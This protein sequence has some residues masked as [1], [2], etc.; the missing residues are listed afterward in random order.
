MEININQWYRRTAVKTAVLIAGMLGG[1]MFLSSV[2]MSFLLIGTVNPAGLITAANESYEESDDFRDAVEGSISEVFEQ[3][4]IKS[5]VETDGAYNP[6]K[7]IDIMGYAETG[8][9]DGYNRSGVAYPMSVLVDWG[10]E[11][12]DESTSSYDTNNVIVCQKPDGSYYYYYLSDFLALFDSG[13]FTIQFED[14]Y[15]TQEGFLEQ[16]EAGNLT[17]ASV[18]GQMQIVDGGGT[19]VYRD[20]WNF[21]RS[22]QEKYEPSGASDL[23][24]LVNRSEELNGKLSLIYNDLALSLGA[25]YRDYQIYQNGW[26]YL[27]EGNTNFTYLYVDEETQEIYTN[28]EEYRNYE[29]TS[30]Y[31]DDMKSWNHVKY[32][33]I[34]P[35]LKECETNMDLSLSEEWSMV[36]SYSENYGDSG[37]FAVAVDTSYPVQD[38]YWEGAAL[39]EKQVPMFN[40]AAFFFFTGAALILISAVWLAAV[41]GRK[42]GSGGLYLTAFDRWKTEIAA[43]VVLLVWA[44]GTWLFLIFLSA[45]GSYQSLFYDAWSY[46]GQTEGGYSGIYFDPAVNQ[47]RISEVM[48]VFVYG[49]FSSLCFFGC[50][51]SFLRRKK[52]NILWKGSLIHAVIR[53]GTE[54]FRNRTAAV[55]G[56]LLFLVFLFVQ[57][58]AILIRSFPAILLAL[59]ADVIGIW[60]VLSTGLAKNRIKK[61]IEEIASGSL[62]YRIELKGLRGAEKDIA[63]KVNEIG[64]GLNR[65]VDEAMRNERLKTDLITN[66]SHDIKTPLTSIINYVDILKHSDITDEKILGYLDILEAKAQRLRVLTEDVVEASK[67]SSGNISLEFM[68]VDLTQL[69]LQTEGELAEK[70]AARSLTVVMNIPEE[71]VVVRVDGRRMWRVL[72]NVMNNAAK[73]AMPGTR[74][75]AD[76]SVREGRAVFTLKNVSEHQLN[77]SADELT[78]RFI[79]GDISRSTEGSGLGL[80]IAK[81]LTAMQG[82]ELELYLDGDLFRV[83]ISFPAIVRENQEPAGENKEIS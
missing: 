61:G 37:I 72:E 63:M 25:I 6:D 68:D 59:A 19:V 3:I 5:V 62:E 53:F 81:S 26:A 46:A 40:C 16:L 22:I 51:V 70:F 31:I 20:C 50:Y 65:A 83:N 47:V 1:A 69:I 10:R 55:K 58:T 45:D 78:E 52:A 11:F 57:W 7:L 14:S 80:S 44:V 38:M 17:T 42:P 73:Y 43:A 76:L 33:F 49:A 21:G 8:Y 27:E 30:E 71:P 54:V 56:G 24:T 75:Y 2:I 79:R 41:A 9:A 35:K 82:G 39:Y 60:Y 77:I 23:L 13:L 18:F 15:Q 4:R 29:N 34:Y 64:R 74:V 28:K 66:V 48:A 36:R 67:V 12:S 32:L